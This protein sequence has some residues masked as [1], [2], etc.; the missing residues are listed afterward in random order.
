MLFGLLCLTF[1]I[2]HLVPGDPARLAAG[3]DASESMVETVRRE[4][5][6][7]RPLRRASSCATAAAWPR[8]DFGESLRSRNTVGGDLARYF[9]NTF[10]LVTLAMLLAVVVGIPLGMLSARLQGP[11]DRS[12]HARLRPSPAWRCRRSG[13]AC[14]LQLLSRSSWAGCRSAAASASPTMPPAPITASAAGRRAAARQWCDVLADAVR[15]RAAGARAVAAL[16]RLDR[17]GEPRRDGGGL[18]SGL[19]HLGARPG[20]GGV[21]RGDAVR[22]EERHAADARDDRPALRLDAG[23]HRAGRDRVRLAGHRALRRERRRIV[24]TSSRSW[25]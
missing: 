3:P 5:G 22:A 16:P 17:A 21:A 24:A 2:S 20:R 9:P 1:A 18:R 25:A 14:M 13:S 6:L 19:H 11:V 10:E 12:H 15:T 8:G 4:Y 7:D 23:R